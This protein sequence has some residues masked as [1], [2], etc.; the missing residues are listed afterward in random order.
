MGMNTSCTNCQST[1]IFI[2]AQC[3]MCKNIITGR[4]PRCIIFL[5]R[6]NVCEV[7][8]HICCYCKKSTPKIWLNCKCGFVCEDCRR[9]CCGE[10]YCPKCLDRHR[11][12]PC[13][14][15]K[16]IKKECQ[17]FSI[18][19]KCCMKMSN[20]IVDDNF[21]ERE[22]KCSEC[23]DEKSPIYYEVCCSCSISLFGMIFIDE[24]ILPYVL[25]EKGLCVEIKDFTYLFV[26]PNTIECV[27]CGLI[28]CKIHNR[29][30]KII[31]DFLCKDCKKLPNYRGEKIETDY[32]LSSLDSI[33]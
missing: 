29:K 23:I 8:A 10:N 13:K 5:N 22:L 2:D 16:E 33:I 32:D 18:L 27:Q 4:C 24:T 25:H 19:C 20:H 28:V 9:G 14:V 11:N 17:P 1:G 30:N 31:K 12:I 6:M 7:C 21:W 26:Q 15:C 3:G